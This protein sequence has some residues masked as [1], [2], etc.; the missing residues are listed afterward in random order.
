MQFSRRQLEQLAPHNPVRTRRWLVGHVAQFFPDCCAELGPGGVE[1]LVDEAVGGAAEEGFVEP[2]HV[3]RF[4]DLVFELGADFA[5]DPRF[6]WAR[7]VLDD[8]GL[9]TPAERS[10]A[11][12]RA[13]LD[14]VTRDGAEAQ[15][16]R[17]EAGKEH[18]AP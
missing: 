1:A 11:L 14:Q 4:V 12:R 5:D 18:H 13:A 3:A 6:P 7:A 8:P 9:R 17:G 16:R 2:L 15:R 10:F